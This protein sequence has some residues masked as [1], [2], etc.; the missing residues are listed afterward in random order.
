MSG[1]LTLLTSAF[2][3]RGTARPLPAGAPAGFRYYVP[4]WRGSAVEVS[5]SPSRLGSHCELQC[6]LSARS[7]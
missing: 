6:F 7:S 2:V 1:N 3:C 4:L 5:S